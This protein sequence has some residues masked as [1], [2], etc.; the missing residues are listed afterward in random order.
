MKN[1]LSWFFRPKVE[2]SQPD[3][4]YRPVEA[5][6]VKQY[7][8][9]R[10]LGKQPH[11]CMA[12]FK[13]AYIGHFGKVSV[14]C[15]NRTYILGTYPAKSLEEIWFGSAAEKLRDYM[16]HD[17]LSLGCQ[18]CYHHINSG[19]FDAA[20]PHSFDHLPLNSNAF[21]SSMEFELS[22]TCNLECIMCNGDFSSSIRKNREKK[23][24]LESVYD[25]SFVDQL[26][27][28][29]PHLK[30]ASFYGGEPFLVDIYYDIWERMASINPDIDIMI[31]TNATILNKKVMS[32]LDR[33]KFNINISLDSI[34]KETYE[35]IRKNAKF[36]TVMDNLHYFHE[37]C[38]N[39]QTNFFISGCAMPQNWQELPDFIHFCNDLNTQVYFHL[40][41]LPRKNSLAFLSS[42]KLEE[43][44]RQFSREEFPS[45]TAMQRK[46]KLHFE[47]LTKQIYY[48]MEKAEENKIVKFKKTGPIQNID[49]L[50][51]HLQRFIQ[52]EDPQK[53]EI[54][55]KSR[56][57]AQKREEML[58][59]LGA[60]TN[61]QDLISDL[62]LEDSIYL[63]ELI[64][65]IISEPLSSL[66]EKARNKAMNN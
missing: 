37:Y 55:A 11:L 2:D 9:F 13:N 42:E 23:P 49:Q 50:F 21:P 46:N 32:L 20:K 52:S 4:N 31:Q 27:P 14:C 54:D 8:K 41:Q 6:L 25:Q 12:P 65:L 26:E 44:H 29:L 39:K 24:P 53:V 36:E 40:V 48:W 59:A 61:I 18:G 19:N 3:N 15:Y 58:Q 1:L 5:N 56:M 43:I 33:M 38:Q 60:Q 10:P 28:F 63:K 30:Q 7:Q 47:G 45:D 64:N 34:Q 51:D 16:R 35:H 62:D 66:M 17:D 22:N 57:L